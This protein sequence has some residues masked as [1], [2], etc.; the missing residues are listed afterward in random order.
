[1]TFVVTNALIYDPRYQTFESWGS[2][3]VEQY[4]AQQLA[5][6]TEDTDWKQWARGLLAIDVFTN[7][8]S[9][10]PDAF[11][12]WYDW[13]AMMVGTYNPSGQ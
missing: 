11:E 12:N 2:L 5:V 9:P 10:D 1:M 4:A 3:M 8:A 6:P 7:E 13:A